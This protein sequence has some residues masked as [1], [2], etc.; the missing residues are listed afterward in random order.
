MSNLVDPPSGSFSQLLRPGAHYIAF[1]PAITLAA[2]WLGGEAALMIV[3][4]TFP[5]AIWFIFGR[6]F[7]QNPVAQIDAVTGLMTRHDWERQCCDVLHSA[8]QN[9]LRSAVFMLQIDD[10]DEVQSRFGRNATDEVIR[11][12]AE[13][14]QSTLRPSDVC[15]HDTDGSFQIALTPQ[16]MMDLEACLQVGGRLARSIEEPLI[17][18]ETK[19]YVSA[20]MGFCLLSR[21]PEIDKLPR[22]E[23]TIEGAKLALEAALVAGP[24][25]IRAFNPSVAA[26]AKTAQ[27]GDAVAALEAGR[28]QAWFQP[29]ISTDT[30]LITGFEALA[31][32]IDPTRGA[33][34]PAEF[35][36]Q[37]EEAGALGRLAEVM[38]YQSLTALR[39]W[40]QAGHEISQVGVNFSSAELSDPEL[41]NKIKWE[42]DRFE[43][44]PSR[45]AVEILESVVA[46]DPDDL[47]TRN[48]AAIGALGCHIDLDDFGTGH[49]SLAAIRRFDVTRIKIDRSFVMK[50][51][52]DPDQ[53]RMIA[54]IIG[55]AE[56]LGLQTLAE[57]VETVGEHALLA[58][59]GCT[60]VQGFGIA[61]PM[62]FDQTLDW[63][64]AHNNKL[65]DPPAIRK[66]K[67][68]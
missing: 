65:Q 58:Q 26:P 36:P 14:I 66:A 16:S 41:V 51:D 60:Q 63:M 43:L 6:Q 33:I 19:I 39:A 45:L 20:S 24:S 61:R 49:A 47:I 23:A 11:Q 57:G 54:A 30:G 9:K 8:E 5:A 25:A 34:P 67:N 56:R 38:L 15:G 1:V 53:Q 68:S 55:M 48:I 40:E 7:S 21:A 31:R 50:A 35:L 42:L 46:Q 32:W 22:A 64:R 62:P 29:Q 52:R 27:N 2:F 4:L 59:L 44:A 18:D 10:I 17:V 28:I 3:A 37:I 12:T 13:R